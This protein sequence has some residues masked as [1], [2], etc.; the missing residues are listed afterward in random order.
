M[1]ASKSES[2]HNKYMNSGEKRLTEVKSGGDSRGKF[3]PLG[4]AI[5]APCPIFPKIEDD[6]ALCLV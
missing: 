6:E 3:P 2:V 1:N 5:D 4:L